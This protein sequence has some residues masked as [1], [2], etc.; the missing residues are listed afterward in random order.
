MV[1]PSHSAFMFLLW[2]FLFLF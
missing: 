2:N 1:E